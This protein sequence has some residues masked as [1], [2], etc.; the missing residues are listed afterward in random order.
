MRPYIISNRNY[1]RMI[2]FPGKSQYCTECRS[3]KRQPVSNNNDVRCQSFQFISDIVPVHR[4]YRIYFGENVQVCGRR[5]RT[6]LRF[7]REKERWILIGKRINRTLTVLI[8]E[9]FGESLIKGCESTAK[10]ICRTN[11]DNIFFQ[12]INPK[13]DFMN[14]F[15]SSFQPGTHFAPENFSQAIP[16]GIP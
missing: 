8:Q 12:V 9:L 4:I 11:Y 7:P 16:P 13:A 14:L 3:H 6:K 2:V 10:G 5:I 15:L 1:F